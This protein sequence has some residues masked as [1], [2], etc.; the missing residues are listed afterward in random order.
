MVYNLFKTVITGKKIWYHTKKH[1]EEDSL[2]LDEDIDIEE[3][4]EPVASTIR[5][6]AQ[7]KPRPQT[8]EL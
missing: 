2:E 5:L 8:F 1:L 4:D 3:G 7:N 6:S